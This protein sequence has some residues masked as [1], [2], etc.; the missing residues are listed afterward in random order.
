MLQ[1]TQP[2][3]QNSNNIYP[4]NTN[5]GGQSNASQQINFI[6]FS[7]IQHNSTTTS[8]HA[9][10]YH[11]TN[12]Q[13]ISFH[14]PLS[15]AQTP[16]LAFEKI[17]PHKATFNFGTSKTFT[18]TTIPSK[19]FTM[20]TFPA[21]SALGSCSPH[22]ANHEEADYTDSF[23]YNR[24]SPLQVS[25]LPN[26]R[27]VATFENVMLYQFDR[28]EGS[29]AFVSECVLSIS[30]HSD[31]K[32]MLLWNNSSGMCLVNERIDVKKNKAKQD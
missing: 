30:E 29:F 19:P 4:Q 2:N 25:L 10:S 24:D 5:L 26:E 31:K 13:E 23:M 11:N 20:L 12:P 21:P 3:T 9:S 22:K 6:P 8:D 15:N 17:R 16:Q 1:N 18:S 32:R 14:Q 27:S 28:E 7:N